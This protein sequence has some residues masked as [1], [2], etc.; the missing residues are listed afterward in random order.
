M[1]LGRILDFA[2]GVRGVV[3]HRQM[4]QCGSRQSRSR[5]CVTN[6]AIVNGGAR[7]CSDEAKEYSNAV[8]DVISQTL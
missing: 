6:M 7:G 2:V 4:V 1:P 5:D 3:W 8:G